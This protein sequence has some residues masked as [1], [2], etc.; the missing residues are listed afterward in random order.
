MTNETYTHAHA[1]D[2]FQDRYP[3]R[4]P[5]LRLPFTPGLGE[6]EQGVLQVC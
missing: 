5:L 1:H 3:R 2:R 6:E 4:L